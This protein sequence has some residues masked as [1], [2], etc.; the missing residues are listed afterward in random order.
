M[1]TVLLILF[2]I[3]ELKPT[4]LALAIS[5]E[6]GTYTNKIEKQNFNPL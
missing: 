5:M 6:K 2:K 1:Q 4:M 3:Q